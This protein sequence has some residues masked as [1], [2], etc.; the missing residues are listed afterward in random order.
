MGTVIAGGRKGVQEA[1]EI[2]KEGTIQQL[3]G[4]GTADGGRSHSVTQEQQVL[5]T[6]TAVGDRRL[7][8]FQTKFVTAR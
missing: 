5:N 1:V 6:G 2:A 4:K 8:R 7:Y 3:V